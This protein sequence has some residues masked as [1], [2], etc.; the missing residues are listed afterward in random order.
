MAINARKGAEDAIKAG[1]KEIVKQMSSVDKTS[2]T[3]SKNIKEV[4]DQTE[5]TGKKMKTAADGGMA[6]VNSKLEKLDGTLKSIAGSFTTLSTQLTNTFSE[7]NKVSGNIYGLSSTFKEAL[8]TIKDTA[9]AVTSVDSAEQ[10][11]IKTNNSAAAK[12][13]RRVVS[14]IST[15]S[16]IRELLEVGALSN[17]K[18]TPIS[19]KTAKTLENIIRKELL[20]GTTDPNSIAFAGGRISKTFQEALLFSARNTRGSNRTEE[21]QNS[22]LELKNRQES[23][24]IEQ[25]E[26][27]LNT[28]KK[29]DEL[30]ISKIIEDQNASKKRQEEIDRQARK[31]RLYDANESKKQHAAEM[32]LIDKK[33]KSQE[34]IFDTKAQRELNKTESE[35]VRN[36]SKEEVEVRKAARERQKDYENQL[37]YE[38]IL[39]R[40]A[41][42]RLAWRQRMGDMFAGTDDVET[43]LQRRLDN[44]IN[45]VK[46]T[47]TRLNE[48]AEN[49]GAHKGTIGMPATSKREIEALRKAIYETAKEQRL[50][51][52]EEGK[53]AQ[54]LGRVVEDSKKLQS[55]VNRVH[56]AFGQLAS[57]A[58]A[59]RGIAAQLRQTMTRIAQPVLRI[60]QGISSQAFKSSLDAMKK[61]ELSEIGFENFF[62]KYAVSSIM[63]NVKQNA[64]LSPMSAAQLASY[65]SQIAPLSNGNSTLAT[66]A[67]MGVAKM[68]QYS[69]SDVTTE[70]EYVV[71]NLRD[72]IAKNKA[73]TIDIR[74]FN[75]AMPALKK[76]LQ[77]M[78][79]EEFLKDGEISIDKENASQLLQAFAKVNE[80]EQVGDIFNKTSETIAGLMERME[81]QAQ[82]LLIDVADFSGLTKFIKDTIHEILESSDGIISDIKMSLQFIA[83][84]VMRWFKSRDWESIANSFS[85]AMNI[86]WTAIKE[87]VG[88][89]RDALGGFD[90]RTTLKNFAKLVGEFIKGIANSYSWLLGVMDSL[91]SSGVLGS[92]LLQAG[93]KVLGFMSG[94]AGVLITGTLRSFGNAMGV[95]NQVIG[96]LIRTLE[97]WHQRLLVQL[98]E[99]SSFSQALAIVTDSSAILAESFKQLT[100]SIGMSIESLQQEALERRAT[101]N[102]EKAQQLAASSAGM[103]AGQFDASDAELSEAMAE[104]TAKKG[105]GLLGPSATGVGTKLYAMI[106]SFISKVISGLLVGSATSM[107]SEKVY[108]AFSSDRLGSRVFGNTVGS[109]AGGAMI[110]GQLGGPLGLLGGGAIGIVKS[111]VDAVSAFKEERQRRV[112]EVKE[113]VSQGNYLRELLEE[114]KSGNRISSNDFDALNSALVKQA[115]NFNAAF[116]N[117]TAQMLKDYL[118]QTVV[119]GRNIHD[120]IVEA[121]KDFE[122]QSDNLWS[123]IES[124][125]IE[126]ANEYANTLYENAGY[127]NAQVAAAILR[128]AVNAGWTNKNGALSDLLLQWGN[129][130]TSEGKDLT[131]AY[132]QD[133]QERIKNGNVGNAQAE[134]GK[135]AN[136]LT[137]LWTQVGQN[138]V[139]D[140]STL[141]E[142][143]KKAVA[144]EFASGMIHYIF[145]EEVSVGEKGAMNRL[146]DIAKIDD[147]SKL[148]LSL[149]PGE[150][151]Q[152]STL[153]NLYGLNSENVKRWYSNSKGKSAEENGNSTYY[154]P[155]KIRKAVEDSTSSI[156]EAFD[157][158]DKNYEKLGL[159]TEDTLKMMFDKS[160]EV[161]NSYSNILTEA[162]LI[163]QNMKKISAKQE[164]SLRK[165]NAEQQFFNNVEK[166]GWVHRAAGGPIRGVD[167]VPTMLQPGE[168]IVRKSTVDKIGLTALNALNTG[169]VGYFAR[170]FGRQNIYGD[171]S[172]ARTW[173]TTSNDN[174][175]SVNNI[176]KVYNNSR[177][178]SLNRYYSLAN[179]LA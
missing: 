79:L 10:K 52:S 143:Q 40:N 116:P 126:K 100:A 136:Q 15:E 113:E 103:A 123:L 160:S 75:R 80:S 99:I 110:G 106:S 5:K 46:D 141:N 86:V 107:I 140:S 133:L 78:G 111:L 118:S 76:V 68:I 39:K 135:I 61:L 87:A 92:G 11:L 112:D 14:S 38:Q 146:F 32:K 81:E 114:T 109:I 56:T 29:T 158:V 73:T 1:A 63:A 30:T 21:L 130:Q 65:V 83:N 144:K 34:A 67:A 156:Q 49:P 72:V 69:G 45:R 150:A 16:G 120:A 70:M 154:I 163:V 132:I 57:S 117:G 3:T 48:Q 66:N 77:E 60:V 62:G 119:N 12:M 36:A 178:S 28:Q 37:K 97:A 164:E 122:E 134:K 6:A 4:G 50:L 101:L 179:R 84:N 71:R 166:Y 142:S 174:R 27:K 102:A 175:K 51:N 155:E 33:A 43:N 82:F 26:Q 153:A 8:K 149:D 173:N 41:E 131:Y 167:T 55:S 165:I 105:G 152:L 172:N 96:V 115:N 139:K 25:E 171:Y 85:E 23:I 129:V 125:E 20:G 168:Y 148:G 88:T 162:A 9:V 17:K 47:W 19:A 89:L 170:A 59:I 151:V 94:N 74:Q 169:N 157:A 2:K 35:R 124:G 13:A 90:W 161:L 58:S 44:A 22:K 64:L 177:G 18:A 53:F 7:L 31:Q 121:D 42:S 128:G 93:S 138:L 98:N 176:V 95:L 145:G 127:S 104:A 91:S 108:N 137:T 159:T 24:R 54:T 147:A